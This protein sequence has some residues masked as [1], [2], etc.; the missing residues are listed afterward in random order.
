MDT[1]LFCVSVQNLTMGLYPNM[2]A[3]KRSVEESSS[4]V[5]WTAEGEWDC[6]GEVL[7]QVEG[8]WWDVV[9]VT[10]VACKYS[11]VSGQLFPQPV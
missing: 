8:G 1:Y 10:V 2:D 7:V 5:H 4:Y 9:P 11:P 3:A 6:E